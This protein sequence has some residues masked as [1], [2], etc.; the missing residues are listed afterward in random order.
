METKLYCFPN[1]TFHTSGSLGHVTGLMKLD[2]VTQI[3]AVLGH[4]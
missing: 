2:A 3:Y 1:K 4:G